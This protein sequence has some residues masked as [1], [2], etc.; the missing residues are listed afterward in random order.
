MF[1]EIGIALSALIASFFLFPHYLPTRFLYWVAIIDLSVRTKLSRMIKR[2]NQFWWHEITPDLFLGGIP[3]ANHD[4]LKGVKKLGVKS[5]LAV[6]DDI[7]VN[8]E[9]FFSTPVR[10]KDWT[11]EGISYRRLR[12]SD[13]QA[14]TLQ[15]LK[16]SVEWLHEQIAKGKLVYVHCKAGRGRSAMIVIAYLIRYH[17]MTL[18]KAKAF[19]RSKRSLVR[20]RP[21]QLARLEEFSHF[22]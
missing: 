10:E 9:T 5:I 1:I 12:C 15:E 11:S 7:E 22:N 19:L 6:L 13:M 16:D 2:L 21:I 17:K 4:H 18:A 14:M 3:L 20:F 8:I